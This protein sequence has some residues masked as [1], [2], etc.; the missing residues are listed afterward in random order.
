MSDDTSPDGLQRLDLALV[1][2][3]L[4]DTRAQGQ[5]AIKAG[6]VT[7]DGDVCK[8]AST[9]V[10]AEQ[11]ITAEKAHPY[12]SRG[13]MKLAHALDVFKVDMTDKIVL[14][15]GASTGGFTDVALRAGARKV[16]AVDVGRDQLHPSLK[17]D[18][19]VISYEATDA[20]KL[21]KNL[22]DTPADIIVCDAS[23]ISLSKLLK[24]VLR[25]GSE[26][27][28]LITLFKP[29]FEVGK[30]NVG[31]GGIVSNQGAVAKARTQFDRWLDE[32]DWQIEKSCTS[33]I[34]GGDGNREYLIHAKRIKQGWTP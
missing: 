29:Q 30:E 2:R 3:G 33:P 26:K 9:K 34:K 6:K 20:R 16:Y 7:I 18:P 21:D 22:I 14:D 1:T 19:R 15:I 28:D 11:V 10:S 25:L 24:P 8:K 31:K 4:M 32:L 13:G 27:A 5:A 23:F 12:V 17:A